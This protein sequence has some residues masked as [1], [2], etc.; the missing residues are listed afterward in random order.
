[1]SLLRQ[2]KGW[3]RWMEIQ[4]VERCQCG[5][6]GGEVGGKVAG[7]GFEVACGHPGQV[8]GVPEADRVPVAG[9]EEGTAGRPSEALP[10]KHFAF[11]ARETLKF[12]TCGGI[13]NTDGLIPR[14]RREQTSVRGPSHAP[15]ERCVTLAEE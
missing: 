2:L 3:K 8:A 1:M 9:D 5:W 13:P 6:D 15:D 7:R 10:V 12:L 4:A 11:R 14:D